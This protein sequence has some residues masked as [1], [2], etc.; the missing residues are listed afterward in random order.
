[1]WAIARNAKITEKSKLKVDAEREARERVS[2][3]R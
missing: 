2:E 3:P 1:M